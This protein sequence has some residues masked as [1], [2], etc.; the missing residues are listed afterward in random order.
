M[1]LKPTKIPINTDPYFA[2][3]VL[4]ADFEGGDL[5]LAFDPTYTEAS[6]QPL[7]G[8][9]TITTNDTWAR[10]W[11]YAPGKST[12]KWAIEIVNSTSE[13]VS[14]LGIG[15]S[16]D[17]TIGAQY[18]GQDANSWGYLGDGYKAHSGY[19]NISLPM[20]TSPTSA[21]MVYIDLDAGSIGVK[22]S[23][24]TETVMFTGQSF[25][26]VFPG[27][28]INGAGSSRTGT[29]NFGA[30]A[31]TNTLPSGYAAW[32]ATTPATDQST[33]NHTLTFNATAQLDTAQSKFGTASLLLDG[34]SDYVSITD[35]V[36]WAFGS[37][38]WTI[39]CHVRF[40]GDPGTAQMNFVNQWTNAGSQ[41]SW[42]VG[43]RN[44]S[45]QAFTSATGSNGLFILNRAWNP[46][47]DTWYHVAFCRENLATNV[48]RAFVD[49]VQ[50]GADDTSIN[51][52]P[53]HFNPTSDVWIGAYNGDA[54]DWLN[55]WVDNVRITKGVCRYTTTFTPPSAPYPTS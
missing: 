5:S 35:S 19:T 30:T 54:F 10:A 48:I 34:N 4:L 15:F 42:W 22:V 6:S 31:F 36:D 7:P 44:N 13:A 52:N 49:G 12:G 39:E 20:T 28:S 40:N 45:L 21:A 14:N 24:G 38:E 50:I 29:I 2:S 1:G 17:R 37:G 3:V 47:G 27:L 55:G 53:T 25:G 46:A 33:S 26:T 9:R 43:Y 11:A 51:A 23:N 41:K 8:P 16:N 18:M 32:D